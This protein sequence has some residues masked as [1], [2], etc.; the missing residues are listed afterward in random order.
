M[1]GTGIRKFASERG[2]TCDKG[3]AYGKV[4]GRYIAMD[5]GTGYKALRVYLYP[6]VEQGDEFAQRDAQILE[7]LTDC[8]LKEFRL[9]REDAV[10]IRGGFAQLIF[11]DTMGTMK[12]IVRYIDEILPKLDAIGLDT[13][14]C[15]CCGKPFENDLD[16][17]L[18][19]GNI[20]PLHAGCVE[21]LSALVNDVDAQSRQGSSL[22]KGTKGAL[23]GAVIGAIPWA[24]MFVLGY[25]AAVCGLLIGYLSSWMYDKFGGRKSKLKIVI[26]AVALVI[27]VVL[28][29]VSGYTADFAI[30]FYE[31]GGGTAA[32]CVE[33]VGYIW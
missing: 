19:D 18:L 23:V 24:A 6:P 1:I 22:L 3:M 17:V 5:E 16:Y 26:V 20:M 13:E 32:E 25:I 15:V 7:A 8:N 10:S 9:H 30:G 12:L 28:G 31:N 33:Y 29:Q 2:M 27:G 4:N 21:Q 11:Y 14:R